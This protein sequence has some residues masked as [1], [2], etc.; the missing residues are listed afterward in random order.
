MSLLS[1]PLAI[2]LIILTF[3]ADHCVLFFNVH[4]SNTKCYKVPR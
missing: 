3:E 4:Y 1:I 2:K